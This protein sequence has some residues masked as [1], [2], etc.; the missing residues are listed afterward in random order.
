MRLRSF[1][2]ALMACGGL[3]L[4]NLN[5]D[6]AII[7]LDLAGIGGPGLTNANNVGANTA[8]PANSVATGT[9][10][11][12]R[13]DDVSGL[14]SFDFSFAG[15]GGS[16]REEAAGGIHFHEVAAMDDPF[17]STGPIAFFL[18]NGTDPD[19]TLNTMLIDPAATSGNLAGTV[20]LAPA[21]VASLLD[22][23]YYLNIHSDLGPAG[24]L[25]GNVVVSAVPEPSTMVVLGL[26]GAGA[27][28]RRRRRRQR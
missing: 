23:R 28:V 10:N 20:N 3:L 14:L 4:G 27:A 2:A 17:T 5:A 16:L 22:G 9:V 21:D 6:A 1:C 13:V 25:R 15:L 26:V 8:S 7:Q 11:D 24:E 19:V 18:N 12:L